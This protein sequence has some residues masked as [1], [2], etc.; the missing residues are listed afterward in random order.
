MAI[1]TRSTAIG[2]FASRTEAAQA[3]RELLEEPNAVT[4]HRGDQTE[5]M[6]TRTILWAAGVQASPLGRLLAEKAGAEVDMARPKSSA[7]Y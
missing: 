1:A 5:R 7:T 4:I 3:V 6:E 2:V